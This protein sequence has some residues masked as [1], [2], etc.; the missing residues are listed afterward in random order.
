MVTLRAVVRADDNFH[1]Q[2]P[3]VVDARQVILA[4]HAVAERDP[5]NGPDAA[6]RIAV[7]AVSQMLAGQREDDPHA[8]CACG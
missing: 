7:G 6:G 2:T 8:D 5:L 3:E 4:A 1:A